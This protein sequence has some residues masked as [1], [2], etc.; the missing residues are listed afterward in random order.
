MAV[1]HL[2]PLMVTYGY[3]HR[4]PEFEICYF[5]SD[6][7]TFMIQDREYTIRAGDVFI[8]NSND[9]H[10]PVLRAARNDGAIVTYFSDRIFGSAE[11][12]GEWLNPFILANRLGANRV[13]SNRRLRNL[14]GELHTTVNQ[15]KGPWQ[16]ASL[17]ILTHVLSLIAC[18]FLQRFDRAR[19]SQCLLSAHRF[20]RV[21]S[22]I[23]DHLHEPIRAASLYKIAGL[24]HSQFSVRFRSTFGVGVA[25]FVQMQRISRAK[26]MLKSTSMT[27]TQI[28]LSTGFNS[29]SF[30]NQVFKK[31]VGSP[32]L[33]YR[34]GSATAIKR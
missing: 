33:A 7:G 32:P 1:L 6:G 2:K 18:D 26:R 23:N 34:L 21:I 20:G 10:Q 9:I 31:H 27:I 8:V 12:S 15:A 11:E 14:I 13:R 4:H 5:P 3:L 29:S 19:Q 17:G 25:T 30:F 28:A 22:Y 24:S 16:L